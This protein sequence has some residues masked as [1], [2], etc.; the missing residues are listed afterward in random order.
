MNK[1]CEPTSWFLV[2]L[3]SFLKMM[4]IIIIFVS[5]WK[6]PNQKRHGKSLNYHHH[7]HHHRW[8]SRH[9]QEIVQRSSPWHVSL[10]GREDRAMKYQTIRNPFVHRRSHFWAATSCF[11]CRWDCVGSLTRLGTS[12]IL[13]SYFCRE[14]LHMGYLPSF[15]SHFYAR[16]RRSRRFRP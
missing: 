10:Q 6:E 9:F 7:R 11:G 14:D 12:Q 5:D 13:Q 1:V 16:G 4:M 8:A 3:W 2:W 15:H